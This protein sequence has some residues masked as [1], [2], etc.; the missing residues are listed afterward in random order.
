MSREEYLRELAEALAGDVPEAVI[1]DNVNYYGSYL[2]QEMA[3]GRTVDE[4]AAEIGE[5]FIVAK[6]IIEH[7]EA[8][9]EAAGDDGYGGQSYGG[10]GYSGQGYG[11]QYQDQGNS[12]P[13]MHYIDLNKW[14]WKVLAIVV[15]F[16]AVTLVFNII[17]GI[18][19]LLMRFAGPLM[20]ICLVVWIV[21]QFKN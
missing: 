10:Q 2:S 18:F 16:F 9:G 5:P 3:K 19:A 13:Q 14:Y 7:S 1:R 8:A 15:L 11:G 21:K 6:T 12:G 4:I 20:M 17:G